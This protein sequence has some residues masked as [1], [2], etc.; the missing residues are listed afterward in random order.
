MLIQTDLKFV[1]FNIF[2]D[3]QINSQCF[4]G[5]KLQLNRKDTRPAQSPILRM[6]YTQFFGDIIGDSSG[7]VSVFQRKLVKRRMSSEFR[8]LIAIVCDQRVPLVKRRT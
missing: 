7:S 3:T 6:F 5:I 4:S 2:N 1:R 8:A